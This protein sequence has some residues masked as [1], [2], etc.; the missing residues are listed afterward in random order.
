[1]FSEAEKQH[2]KSFLPKDVHS[3]HPTYNQQQDHNKIINDIFDGKNFYHTNPLQVFTEQMKA[4]SFTKTHQKINTLEDRLSQIMLKNYY[5]L[6][7]DLLDIKLERLK[8]QEEKNKDVSFLVKR[9][10]LIDL[11]SMS[12]ESE[13][14]VE[15]INDIKVE[16]SIDEISECETVIEVAHEELKL[17]MGDLDDELFENRKIEVQR[18]LAM[19][20]FKTKRAEPEP[21]MPI[22]NIPKFNKVTK[23][24][25]TIKVK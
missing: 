8:I 19:E 17:D 15:S 23:N 10:A 11:E 12:E 9:N 13:L 1:L 22:L 14:S 24:I 7:S 16:N 4:G 21:I 20:I 6:T 3:L 2:L 18:A 25:L 5:S